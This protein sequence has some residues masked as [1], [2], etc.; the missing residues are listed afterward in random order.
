MIIFQKPQYKKKKLFIKIFI[1]NYEY[2][3]RDFNQYLEKVIENEKNK[4]IKKILH[5][6]LKEEIG[7]EFS[8]DFRKWPHRKIFNEI[9]NE[10]NVNSESYRLNNEVFMTVKLWRDMMLKNCASI[11]P[12]VAFGT[13]GFGT[14]LIVPTLYKKILNTLNDENEKILTKTAQYFFE[15]HCEIDIIHSQRIIDISKQL[16]NDK[17]N[18][19]LVFGANTALQLRSYFWDVLLSKIKKNKF[20]N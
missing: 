15:S 6:N 12:G 19:G 2:Y 16:S 1:F 17:F 11:F 3:T 8:K 5:E 9:C 14:E 7:D 4:D 18:E 13:I 10:L 20:D